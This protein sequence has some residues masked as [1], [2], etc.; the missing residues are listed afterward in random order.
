MS[1]AACISDPK[2]DDGPLSSK[3][4]IFDLEVAGPLTAVGNL[5]PLNGCVF[6]MISP[7]Q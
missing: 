5:W 1:W 6:G 3:M 7:I 2:R 4:K